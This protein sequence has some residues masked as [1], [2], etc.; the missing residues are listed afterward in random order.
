MVCWRVLPR[1]P[2]ERR[3]DTL[4]PIEGKKPSSP[5]GTNNPQVYG[6]SSGGAGE[7]EQEESVESLC[8][9]AVQLHAEAAGEK[10][11]DGKQMQR[12]ISLYRRALQVRETLLSRTG[13]FWSLWLYKFAITQAFCTEPY[14][15]T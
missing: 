3:A 4:K 8:N 6:S 2:L 15:F 13:R 14:F 1:G 10:D 9:E 5:K 11:E 12:A 7:D